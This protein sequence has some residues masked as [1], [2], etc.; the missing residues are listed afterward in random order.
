MI[1]LSKIVA[2]AL[3]FSFVT[4]VATADRGGFGRRNK[5]NFNI[6]TANTLRNSVAYNVKSGLIYRGHTIL[7][8]EKANGAVYTN[9]IIS[10]QKGNSIY[11][12]PYKQKVVSQ[13]YSIA[14][15]YK[16]IIRSK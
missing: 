12:L 3:L 15:G 4:L 13:S 16:L 9:S 14:S 8:R 1:K 6:A 5:I 7:N 10:Y 11:I 2:F